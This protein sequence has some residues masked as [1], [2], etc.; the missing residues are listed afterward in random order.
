MNDISFKEDIENLL[1]ISSTWRKKM[2]HFLLG[3]CRENP[4]RLSQSALLR[5]PSDGHESEPLVR[6]KVFCET[7]YSY[8][9]IIF[10]QMFNI[11]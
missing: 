3:T 10:I 2:L 5:M 4:D 8:T 9:T 1:K 6:P 7:V 11:F